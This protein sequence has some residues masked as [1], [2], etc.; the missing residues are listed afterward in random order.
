[1]SEAAVDYEA[2][3]AKIRAQYQPPS[4]TQRPTDYLSSF[5]AHIV[6]DAMSSLAKD[7]EA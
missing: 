6:A 4:L 2:L 1:M 7:L 5:S 3:A